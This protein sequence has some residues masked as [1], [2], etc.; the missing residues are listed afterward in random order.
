MMKTC[1]KSGDV[2]NW[3]SAGIPWIGTLII[4]I[5]EGAGRPPIRELERER[6]WVRETVK[7]RE[8]HPHSDRDTEKEE[9]E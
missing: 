5:E 6:E 9:R 8:R 2:G 7:D 4:V 3:S 1:C